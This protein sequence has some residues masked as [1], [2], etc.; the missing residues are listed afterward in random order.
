MYKL[1]KTTEGHYNVVEISEDPSPAPLKSSISSRLVSSS[2]TLGF[3]VGNLRNIR[4]PYHA[5]I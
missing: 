2:T 4:F 1:F 3:R 5:R